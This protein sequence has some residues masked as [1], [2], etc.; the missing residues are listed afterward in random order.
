MI[1][2]AAI[3]ALSEYFADASHNLYPRSYACDALREI[4]ESYPESRA[5]CI[6]AIT[7]TLERFEENDYE[8]NAFII[9]D[10]AEIKAVETLP[11]IEKAFE[12][13]RVD[14][15]IINLDYTLV[16]M[17]L[18]EPEPVGELFSSFE[19]LLS[20][21]P[22]PP[23]HKYNPSDFEIVD[24]GF[25]DDESAPVVDSLPVRAS[26]PLREFKP[27]KFSRN[28]SKKKKKKR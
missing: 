5:A 24:H 10:L 3:P 18:K 9:D 8:L 19:E 13:D 28:K 21:F 16:L 17:G 12:S 26:S 1:G 11:L 6:E 15:F 23:T 22:T 25:P 20:R 4:A 2:P 14:E 27:I 7:R